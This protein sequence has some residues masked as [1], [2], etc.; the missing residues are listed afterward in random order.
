MILVGADDA[1]DEGMT[2]DVALG[3]FDDGDAFHGLEGVLGLDE[4]GLFVGG[5]IDLGDVAGDDLSVKE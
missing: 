5:E 4:A 1:L 2:D 3:E